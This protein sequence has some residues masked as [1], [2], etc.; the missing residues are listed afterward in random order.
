MKPGDLVR[1]ANRGTDLCMIVSIDDPTDC[2]G[3]AACGCM[4]E[5]SVTAY[6]PRCTIVWQSGRSA[7]KTQSVMAAFIVK[8]AEVTAT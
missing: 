4:V 3:Y 7:G 1:V 5:G 6:V 8:A 2:C